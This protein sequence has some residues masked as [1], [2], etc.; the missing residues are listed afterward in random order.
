M[1][2]IEEVIKK[3][4][5]VCLV[6]IIP[7]TLIMNVLPKHTFFEILLS[8]IIVI[9]SSIGLSTII[10]YIIYICQKQE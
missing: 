1:D 6:S 7:M 8:L 9:L 5:W 10:L 4:F 2:N 3:Y